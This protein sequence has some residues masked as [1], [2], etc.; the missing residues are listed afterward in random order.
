MKK[1]AFAL[2]KG[3]EHTWWYRGRSAAVRSLLARAGA[4]KEGHAL[5]YGAGFG[6]MYQTLSQF[7]DSVDAFEPDEAARIAASVRGYIRTYERTEGIE[8]TRYSLI[9]AFDVVEHI[10]N[11]EA[12][13]LRIKRALAPGGRLAI[14]VP[15]FPFLWSIHDET[16]NHFRRY[17][18]SSL[19]RLLTKTGYVIEEASYWNVSLFPVA[20]C[21][22][23]L[24]RS[25]EGGL[26][27]SPF[28]NEILWFV[29]TVEAAV[30]RVISL[31]FGVSLAVVARPAEGSPSAQS[32][33][34]HRLIRKYSFLV[35]YLIV[36]LLGG[37]IQTL[38]LYIW[39]DILRLTSTYLWGVV[40]GFLIALAVTFVLQKYWTF[41]DT[42]THRTHTQLI[43]YS[44]VALVN[45]ALNTFFIRAVKEVVEAHRGDFFHIWYLLAQIGAV[46]IVA[47]MSFIANYLITFR[48][49]R[50]GI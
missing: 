28:I 20:A 18:R 25:G 44:L 36:G 2:L 31:P 12:F 30:M 48:H 49:A 35:R 3:M 8:D 6:G 17:T 29:L 39:V 9:G 24:G 23:L 13:L 22:R 10:E 40:I 50:K 19:E 7:A 15:A 42:S 27:T 47:A 37:L 32:S 26:H 4:S 45:L 43:S 16:H 41:K 1:E 34:I 33:L 46:F 5:D 21:M 38:T 11:H 14:T